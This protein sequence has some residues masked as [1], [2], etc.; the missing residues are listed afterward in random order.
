MN[1]NMFN[2]PPGSRVADITVGGSPFEWQNPEAVRVA[3][4]V[5][6]GTVSAISISPET[7]ASNYVAA[8]LLGGQYLLNPRQWI[9]V[10]YLLTPS[11][12]YT[13]L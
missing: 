10:A 9:K 11:M 7:D 8:G 2:G 1:G 6:G 4:F 13:P 3:V 5:S 12:K